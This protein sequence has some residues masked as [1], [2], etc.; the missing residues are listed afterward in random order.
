MKTKE[1]YDDLVA[2]YSDENLN[3]ITAKLI[4]LYKQ[5]NYAKIRE[6]AN[7]ISSY[8]PIDE[9]K[10]AKCFSKLIMLYHPDKGEQTRKMINELHNQNN[11]ES[12]NK[13]AHILVLDNLESPVEFTVDENVD[14]NPE[15]AWDVDKYDGF[16][17]DNDEEENDE[18]DFE[19]SFYNLIKIIEYGK[20]DI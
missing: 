18:T 19:K 20:V 9:E 6:I 10:D 17:Y 4:L 7:K 15:Y 16:D 12:L 1:L 2:A 8:I 5:K 13:Y 11:Y 3:Q 14:Y